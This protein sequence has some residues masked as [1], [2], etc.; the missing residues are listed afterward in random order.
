MMTIFQRATDCDLLITVR[1][2]FLYILRYSEKYHNEYSY[3][4]VPSLN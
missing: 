3:T 4:G 2:V 1:I